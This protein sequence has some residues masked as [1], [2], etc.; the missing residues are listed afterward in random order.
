MQ[1][2]HTF[3]ILQAVQ[4]DTAQSILQILEVRVYPVSQAEQI[5]FYEQE[6]HFNISQEIIEQVLEERL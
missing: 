5:L 4:E 1:V 3:G 6:E 2:E